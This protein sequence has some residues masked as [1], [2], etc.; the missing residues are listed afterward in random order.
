MVSVAPTRGHHTGARRAGNRLGRIAGRVALGI[1]LAALVPMVALMIRLSIGP[2]QL[3]EA[4]RIAERVVSD[5]LGGGKAASIARAEVAFDNGIS[6]RLAD[7]AVGKEADG[8]S[9]RIPSARIGLQL[10]P[11]LI[12]QFRPSSLHLEGPEVIVD[13]VE[14]DRMRAAMASGGEAPLEPVSEPAAPV[15]PA[16]APA[17]PTAPPPS[18]TVPDVAGKEPRAPL[19]E[20]SLARLE[21]FGQALARNVELIRAEGLDGIT[22]SGGRLEIRQPEAQGGARTLIFPE[23]EASSL[24]GTPE[25]ELDAGLSARGEVGRWS[26]RLRQFPAEGER[27][28]R[29]EFQVDD[30][31]MRDLIGFDDPVLKVEMP[32]YPHVQADFA[33]DGRLRSARLELRL[34]AGLFR[35]GIETTDEIALDE[36]RVDIGWDAVGDRYRIEQATI[37][38]GPTNLSLKGE[39]VP[40]DAPDQ[41]RF[42]VQHRSGIF[43]PRD[44][45]GGGATLDSLGV[46]GTWSGNRKLLE[47]K[48]AFLVVS[49]AGLRSNGYID[50]T[51]AYPL[52]VS[53]TAFTPAEPAVIS[54]LWPQFMG[55]GARR[56]FLNNVQAGRVSDVSVITQIPLLVEPPQWPANAVTMKG[57]FDGAVVKTFGALPL[58]VGGEG[59]FSIENR[60][61]EAVVEKGQLATRYPKRP[62]IASFRM[63]V[64]N[65]FLRTPRGILDFRV[66][67]DAGAIGEAL[68]AEPLGV[69]NKGGIKPDGLAG[70]ADLRG[71]V[72][73]TFVPEQPP[74]DITYRVEG[75]L[76]KFGSPAPIGGRLFSDGQLKVVADR[77]GATIT[78]KARID[79]V[80]TEVKMF[81]PAEGTSAG[82]R[83]DFA[84]VLD[85][86]T[87]QRMGLDLAGL[88]AGPIKLEV[89]Q[90]TSGEQ[91]KRITADLGGARLI[92]PQFGWT[93][94]T[95]VPAKASLDIVEDDKG[96]RIDNFAIDSEGLQVR[97]GLMVDK[98]K[99]LVSADLQKF[100]LRRGDDA[101]LKMQRGADGA[102]AINFDASSF[103]IRSLLQSM[104]RQGDP[105]DV[106]PKKQSDMNIKARAA[107][108][109][110]FNDVALT[111]VTI[112][113]QVRAQVVTRLQLTGRAAGGRSVEIQIRPDGNGKRSVLVSSD[114]AGAALAFMDVYDRM[115]GGALQL[116]AT[117]TGPSSA[118]GVVR[119][120][121]FQ[122]APSKNQKIENFETTSEGV[123]QVPVREVPITDAQTFDRFSVNF[124]MRR[125]VITLNEGV[126]KG[127]ATGA[128]MAG[129]IDL[130][131]QRLQVTGTFIP[132]FAI[133]NLVGRIPLLGEIAGAGRNEGLVGVTFKVVGS[134]EEPVLQFNPLSAITPGIFRKLLE[135]R[136][137]GNAQTP[138]AE[139][140]ARAASSQIN[141]DAA[142]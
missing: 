15:P 92:I 102:L 58:A 72:E 90:P 95:G 29:L 33:R 89:G 101:K 53:S 28:R 13:I 107:R 83:R 25:A 24:F 79:G 121:G 108:L 110:G 140:A 91:I 17:P 63:E 119:I 133:N 44:V 105:A 68:N 114:D 47:Y 122:L 141:P 132:V 4:A 116:A 94:G 64:P 120:V 111:D 126:A 115:R 45:A 77:K 54:R 8:F 131:N 85:D 3:D 16:A 96:S 123:R 130:N 74:T 2:L 104:K 9:M 46:T 48:D 127:D 40:G 80:A 128:T 66:T 65:N 86:V 59:R 5:A 26:M 70:T 87:R 50:F 55:A 75:T 137:E 62:V 23:L 38:V 43:A 52:F 32:F 76:D 97:G 6:I 21:A 67:G 84:M 7:I 57:R 1:V 134:I 20:K 30:V 136:V 98:E 138:S 125:G 42:A 39:I 14:L 49:G 88:V 73:M 41:W 11:M 61:F 93:K 118:D 112:E 12:G 142:R 100:A 60:R 71:R 117:L 69:L 22:A 81:E 31:T 19:R 51:G 113:A 103:D 99:R 36:A 37:A 34:G 129:Q 135:Y 10:V 35:F 27:G 56:W 82:E 124:Q 78:G 139:S 106:D 109:I 18:A